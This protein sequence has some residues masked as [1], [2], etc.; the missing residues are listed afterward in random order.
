MRVLVYGKELC[1]EVLGIPRELDSIFWIKFTL[2]D[3]YRIYLGA[4]LTRGFSIPTFIFIE[5][6]NHF[7]FPLVHLHSF[8]AEI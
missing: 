2:K 1:E 4:S 7:T 8:P 6:L 5:F 3:G